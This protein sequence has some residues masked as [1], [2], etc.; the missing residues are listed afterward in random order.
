M[1]N[2]HK[3]HIHLCEDGS[4]TLFSQS[5]RQYF[6]NPNGAIA[7]SRHVF[8]RTPG[9]IE[10]LA[11][12][13]EIRILEVGFGTGLNLLLLLE[14]FSRLGKQPNLVYEAAEAWPLSLDQVMKLNYPS[15]IE[16][17]NGSEVLAAIFR[18]LQPG[19]NEIRICGHLQLRLH[20]GS[21]DTMP[22]PDGP[23]DVILFDPFSLDVNPDLWK[24]AVFERLAAWSTPDALLATYGAASAA[25]AAMA[26]GGWKV[27]RAEGALGK[28]EMSLAALREERLAPWQRVD[29]KRL[30]ERLRAGEF[31]VRFGIDT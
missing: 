11:G 16:L 23:V 10:D 4:H 2:T 5:F 1:P 21:F 12:N 27:A 20:V 13:G 14:E 26:S 19:L 31:D 24:P 8:F 18:K 6:H 7:E 3:T 22:Q 30:V 28:R 17:A 15:R 29:E 25:R 9:W